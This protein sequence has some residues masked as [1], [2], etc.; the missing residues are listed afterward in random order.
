ML[1]RAD[2]R[3]LL[4]VGYGQRGR[5]WHEVCR[6][7]RDAVVVGVVDPDPLAQEAAR[8]SGLPAW[9]TIEEGVQLGG[10]AAIVASPPPE[11][12]DQTIACLRLGMAVLVEKPFALSLEAA[13]QVA[14]ES[15]RLGLPVAVAQ[16]FRFL[17]RERAVRKALAAGVGRP[18]SA[19]IISA[20]PPTVAMP[21]VAA[22]EH[23][24]LWDICIHH[25][26]AL[27]V[28]FGAAPERV[29]MKVARLGASPA[30]ERLLFRLLL[31][32]PEGPAVVYQHSEGAPGFYHSEWIE[33]EQR[34]ILVNDQNVRVLFPRHRARRVNPPRGPQPEQA[35]LDDFL[36]ALRSGT[37]PTLSA[38]DNLLTV[39][40]VE[41]AVRAE[42]LG[43][44]V[45]PAEVGEAAGVAVGVDGAAHG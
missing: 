37:A 40:T 38:E 22:I 18:L 11:H 19:T 39:A 13:V 8:R 28:R 42:A 2:R 15:T 30:D 6:R 26:D 44:P 21:H 16:N 32:W 41:A 33:G 12:P 36:G 17:R 3:R 31:E 7:R 20:R 9:S 34:A 10:E 5:Q 4:L 35:V 43:R 14:Q 24:A 23:G 1:G 45:T 25:L 29:E 27:R